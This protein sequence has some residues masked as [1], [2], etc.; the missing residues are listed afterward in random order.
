MDEESIE[1]RKRIIIAVIFGIMFIAIVLLLV[2]NIF[3]RSMHSNDIY[4]RLQNKDS[5][6][7]IVED[8]KCDDCE[9]IESYFKSNNIEYVVM[10]KKYAYFD[11][12]IKL[13]YLDSVLVP[14]IIIVEDGNVIDKMLNIKDIDKDDLD[15]FFNMN[16]E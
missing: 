7:I 15:D 5:M 12:T 9:F 4:Q 3:N 13:L 8:N 1:L 10:D 14:S 6:N 16:G 11:E 2:D